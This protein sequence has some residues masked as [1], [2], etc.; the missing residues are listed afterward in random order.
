MRLTIILFFIFLSLNVSASTKTIAPCENSDF[1]VDAITEDLICRFKLRLDSETEVSGIQL[2]K[3]ADSNKYVL[4]FV[5]SEGLVVHKND[6]NKTLNSNDLMTLVDEIDKKIS[7]KYELEKIYFDL[8][9]VDSIWLN[10]SKNINFDSKGIVSNHMSFLV[11]NI[12][13]SLINENDVLKVAKVL[14]H[15]SKGEINI[16]MNSPSFENKMYGMKWKKM[17]NI[18]NYGINLELTWFSIN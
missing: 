13:F 7:K 5:R 8:G 12:K 18:D 17:K 2:I 14:L 9:L 10:V 3:Y 16:G 6:Q 11:D 1:L 4:R 15:K